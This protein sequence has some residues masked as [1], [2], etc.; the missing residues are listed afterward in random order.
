[1]SL[2]FEDGFHILTL[3]PQNGTYSHISHGNNGRWLNNTFQPRSKFANELGREFWKRMVGEWTRRVSNQKLVGYVYRSNSFCII[4]I[5]TFTTSSSD[6]ESHPRDIR[7]VPSAFVN[8]ISPSSS[9]I[10]TGV[11]HL[12]N[13]SARSPI[14]IRNTKVFCGE[15]WAKQKLLSLFHASSSPSCSMCNE[16][17]AHKLCTLFKSTGWIM[18]LVAHLTQPVET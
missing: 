12:K 3:T 16:S 2:F 18:K 9:L 5:F 6:L 1:M 15:S 11:V 13:R 17:L 4:I 10:F 7:C 14:T 8:V